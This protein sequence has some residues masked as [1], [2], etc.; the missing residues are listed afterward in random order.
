MNRMT[1]P[2]AKRW[3]HGTWGG[4]EQ[5]RREADRRLSFR[6]KLEWNAQALQLAQKFKQSR[7]QKSEP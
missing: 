1:E 7:S 3:H 4:A 6:Q 5:A 2:Q